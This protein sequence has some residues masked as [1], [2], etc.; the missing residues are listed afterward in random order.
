[1]QT[2]LKWKCTK[3]GDVQKSYSD[4]RWDMNMCKCGESGVDLEEGYSRYLGHVK[5]LKITQE[6]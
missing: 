6:D 4:R 5:V 3:C 2:I 1:M